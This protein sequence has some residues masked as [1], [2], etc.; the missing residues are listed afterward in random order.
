MARCPVCHSRKGKRQCLITNEF[1]CS[2]C[3]GETRKDDL[4]EDCVHYRSPKLRRKYHDIPGYSV[5]EMDANGELQGYGNIIESALCA[6]D[7]FSEHTLG[8]EVILR[9]LALLL[10]DYHF[11][12]T[13]IV[14]EDKTVEEG[15]K[16]LVRA[17]EEDL[18]DI[19]D[20]IITKIISTI[21]FVARRRTEG[22]REY[23]DFI[24][25]YIGSRI[26]SGVQVFGRNNYRYKNTGMRK[27]SEIVLEMSVTL[28][29]S[30]APSPSSE[31]AHAALL[32]THV[33]WNKAI[34]SNDIG[35][36]YRIFL[37]KFE[38]SNFVLWDE[39]RIT[40]HQKIIDSLIAFKN[41]F[42]PDDLRVIHV[43]GMREGNVHVEWSDPEEEDVVYD[44]CF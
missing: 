6:F 12:D 28:L 15:Y 19:S 31:A 23:L 10:D 27:M 8:D 29:K 11:N 7:R 21:Y 20:E 3:C 2:L 35:R 40:D 30:P 26:A 16:R 13:D 44:K 1:V 17:I 41:E 42:Y 18:P 38:N 5:P 33:A 4:C 34:G 14:C 37:Q 32:F 22:H 43:C 24:H 39:F 9:V 36:T 25:S